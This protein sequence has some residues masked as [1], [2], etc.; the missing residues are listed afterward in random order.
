MSQI[1]YSVITGKNPREILMLRG[2]G[3][4]W[5]RCRFCDY[6]LDFSPDEEDNYRVNLPELQKV[7]GQFHTLEVINSGSFT[8]LDSRTMQMIE[9]VC[10]EKKIRQLHFETHWIHRKEIAHWKSHFAELG[11]TL[12]IKMGV[13]TFDPVFRQEVLNKGMGNASPEEISRYADE[14]CLLFGLSGQTEDSMRN[15]METGLRYFERVCVNIMVENTT[16]IKPDP[17]V[18]QIFEQNLYHQYA[19]NPRMDIL[20]SNTDF[21]VGAEEIPGKE[22]AYD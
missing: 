6:H 16:D 5:H 9:S 17:Q 10:L 13:E 19:K 18:I 12:K 15:D 7:T 8:D 4:R 21:G 11:I 14:V 1:R 2:S 22:T 3:C 20:L